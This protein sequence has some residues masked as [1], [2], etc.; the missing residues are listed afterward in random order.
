ML[1]YICVYTLGH[2]HLH[3][4]NFNKTF[5][6][7]VIF[8]PDGRCKSTVL[9]KKKSIYCNDKRFVVSIVIAVYG[10][11]PAKDQCTQT[12]S[13]SHCQECTR[14]SIQFATSTTSTICSDLRCILPSCYSCTYIYIYIF[15]ICQSVYL[16]K[17]FS[18]KIPEPYI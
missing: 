9:T 14:R 11:R 16:C 1:I 13:V 8:L 17:F 10:A 7:F 5:N 15:Y 2:T 18:E 4:D 6:F 3:T 12:R